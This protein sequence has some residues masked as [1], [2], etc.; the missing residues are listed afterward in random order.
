MPIRY[1]GDVALSIWGEAAAGQRPSPVT[2]AAQMPIISTNLGR[3]E[4]AVPSEVLS[5]NRMPAQPARGLWAVR[6]R[7]IVV[8]FQRGSLGVWLY[9][10]CEQ[11]SVSGSA[12]PYAHRFKLGGASWHAEGPYFGAELWN[13]GVARGDVL[14]GLAITGF[15]FDLSE[16]S[17]REARLALS[18]AGLGKGHFD[19][20]SRQDATPTVFSGAYWGERSVEVT[21]DG[22]SSLWVTRV[23]FEVKRKYALRKAHDGTDYHT[24][25]VLGGIESATLRVAGIWDDTS[26]IRALA[27]GQGEHSLVVTVKDPVDPGNYYCRFT[28]QEFLAFLT[29]ASAVSAGT[30]ELEVELEAQAYYADGSLGSVCVIDLNDPTATY[31]G[32]IQ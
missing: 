1:A 30:N 32:L 6:D 14:D 12:A 3:T 8:P 27:T 29:N 9:K 18:V 31:V 11:Y 15:S 17:T 28:F 16:E 22:A 19:L 13:A 24:H 2:K 21:I 20:A 23:A 7:E 5:G 4:Q 26:A 10:A 25:C